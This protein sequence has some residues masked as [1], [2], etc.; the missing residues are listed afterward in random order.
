MIVI[1]FI[2]WL[3]IVIVVTQVLAALRLY[4]T[5][6]LVILALI[7]VYFFKLRPSGVDRNWF[8]DFG[9][10]ISVRA[11]RDRRQVRT[12]RGSGCGTQPS[13][14][15]DAMSLRTA[16]SRRSRR[17]LRVCC[18]CSFL[19][20]PF[21]IVLAITYYLR[22]KTPAA[23]VSLSPSDSYTFMT[24]TKLLETNQLFPDGI[25]PAGVSALLALWH[26]FSLGLDVADLIRFG[27][28]L[29]TTLI[30]VGAM[31]AV[32]RIT[33]NAGAAVFAAS[34]FGIFGARLEF[35]VPFS[36]ESAPL[37][38]EFSL[39]VGLLTLAFVGHGCDDP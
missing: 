37:P 5:L 33:K 10:R 21:V 29:M 12:W 36:R 6:T 25:Y 17:V 15:A 32:L 8:S 28:P 22:V 35:V 19:V 30:P 38:Q 1:N 4:E 3:A 16:R 34:I 39:A 27:G 2:R 11:R 31:Y 13:E 18:S 24:W 26:K 20:V 23:H 14:R 9:D 7:A